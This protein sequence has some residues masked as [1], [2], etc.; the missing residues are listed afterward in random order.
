MISTPSH[1]GDENEL[2]APSPGRLT[3]GESEPL[4]GVRRVRLGLSLLEQ[5][6]LRLHGCSFG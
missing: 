4:K 6:P 5:M 3:L 1:P 2:P